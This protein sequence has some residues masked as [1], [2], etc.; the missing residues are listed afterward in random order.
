MKNFV[1]I[2]CFKNELGWPSFERTPVFQAESYDKAC[3]I[4]EEMLDNAFTDKV[5]E[6]FNNWTI[7]VDELI[8]EAKVNE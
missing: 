7:D 1:T 3:G 4:G 8:A 2:L 6:G 5:R